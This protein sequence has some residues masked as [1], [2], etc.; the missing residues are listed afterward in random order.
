[1]GDEEAEMLASALNHNASLQYLELGMNNFGHIGSVALLKLLN[2]IS[3]IDST[4]NS[5]HTI[6]LHTDNN[7]TLAFSE[8]HV[9]GRQNIENNNNHEAAGRA[10][11]IYSQLNSQ[12][13]KRLC[14]LQDIKYSVGNIFADIEPILLP[15]IIALI[16][17]EHGQSELYCTHFNFNGTRSIVIH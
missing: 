5:K 8:L 6:T 12:N 11:V 13:R 16:G 17:N 15:T 7:H 2:D 14:Q 1:M 3:S 9:A 4:Y 10:K